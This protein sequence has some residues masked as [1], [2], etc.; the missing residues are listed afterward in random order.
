MRVMALVLVVG[1]SAAIIRYGDRLAA[2]GSYGY[3]GL[4]LLNL[5]ASATLILP[6]PGLALAFAA[7]SSFS[8]LGAGLAIGAGST[9]GE[10]T[11]YIAG[12]SGR[13]ALENSERWQQVRRWMERYGLWVLFILSLVPNPLFDIAGITAGMMRIPIWKYLAACGAGKIIKATTLAYI[14]AGSIPWLE[15]LIRQW[16]GS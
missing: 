1:V 3:L 13:G 15:G 6:V 11:G 12:Y 4:F 5:L 9:F 10:L 2:L 16:T 8:P 7:G 14:G